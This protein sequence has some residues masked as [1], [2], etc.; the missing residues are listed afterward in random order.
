MNRLAAYLAQASESQKAFAIRIG[1]TQATV[2][3]LCTDAM[4]PSLS[5][6]SRIE[7][8]TGGVVSATGWIETGASV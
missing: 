7:R 4:R 8:E 2:S 1:S 6:A 5:L 3:R